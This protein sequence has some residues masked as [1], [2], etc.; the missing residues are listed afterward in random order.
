MARNV[1]PAIKCNLIIILLLF[2]M[3][4]GYLVIFGIRCNFAIKR[5]NNN[6]DWRCERQ[7]STNRRERDEVRVSL[8]FLLYCVFFRSTV[9]T[10]GSSA[11]RPCHGNS[12]GVVSRPRKIEH[13][14]E[15]GQRSL[16]NFKLFHIQNP[17]VW[18]SAAR[19]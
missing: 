7:L 4:T 16:S 14:V 9:V 10:G 13:W 2:Y 11:I 18:Y 5:K 12:V 8:S 1:S 19:H 3:S 17:P 15:T 6:A